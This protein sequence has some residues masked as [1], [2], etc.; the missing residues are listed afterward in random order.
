[1]RAVVLILFLPTVL[2]WPALSQQKTATKPSTTIA[3]PSAAAGRHTAPVDTFQGRPVYA[4][5]QP[6]PAYPGGDLSMYSA[7]QR[8]LRYPS[9][10]L[11][12]PHVEG[13]VLVTIIV[14]RAGQ[15]QRPTVTQSLA[16]GGGD[17]EAL[18]VVGLLGRFEPGR[19]DG[20]PV[21]VRRE[22]VVYFKFRPTR[23]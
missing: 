5:A 1:M 19:R 23:G 13:K 14:D 8:H 21:D 17:K 7:I 6:M 20:Q 2:A 15:V 9:Q 18:R 11:R 12:A 22:V 10:W 16:D 4:S 3:K